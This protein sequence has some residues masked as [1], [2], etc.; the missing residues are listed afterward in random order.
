MKSRL[1]DGFAHTLLPKI[2]ISMSEEKHGE[3]HFSINS[4]GKTVL[5]VEAFYKDFVK[6]CEI[7]LAKDFTVADKMNK[8]FLNIGL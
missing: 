8:S 1:R 7:V 3:E 5:V 2:G 6:C 4:R